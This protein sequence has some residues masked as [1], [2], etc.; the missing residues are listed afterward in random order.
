MSERGC[1][2][3]RKLLFLLVFFGVLVLVI[4]IFKV[5]LITKVVEKTLLLYADNYYLNILLSFLFL[6]DTEPVIDIHPEEPE[7][8]RNQMFDEEMDQKSIR[9]KLFRFDNFKKETYINSRR[10]RCV[11]TSLSVDNNNW[12]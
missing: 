7:V 5:I 10:S 4:N 11:R 3:L 2:S 8:D 9:L 6:Q 12:I 1:L